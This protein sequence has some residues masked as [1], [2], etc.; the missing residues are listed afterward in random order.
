MSKTL[1]LLWLGSAGAQA[2]H[3]AVLDSWASARWVELEAPAADAPAGVRY[4]DALSQKLEELLDQARLAASSLDD[5]TAR[6]RLTDIDRTL[7]RN[8]ALPQ[9]AWLMAE[10]L[11]VEASIAARSSPDARSKLLERAAILEGRRAPPFGEPSSEPTAPTELTVSLTSARI[12]DQLYVDGQRVSRRVGLR[13]GEHHVRV[14]RRER[15]VWAGWVPVE[16]AGELGLPIPAPVPCSLDD[17]EGVSVQ[18]DRVSAAPSTACARWAVARP[19]AGGGIEIASCRGAS[20]GPLMTW[21]RHYGAVYSG[22]PQPP[23]EPGFPAWAT[24]ALVGAGAA[25]LTGAVLWQAGAFDEP[26]PGGRRFELWGPG[27][28]GT[29]LRSNARGRR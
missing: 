4:D 3:E 23:P 17:L 12:T 10:A 19:A 24:W 16:R 22:P 29:G 13:A 25:A 2:T 9:A 14:V 28:R 18:R 11:Q 5:A 8:A 26:E 6:E 15:V 20:C 1:V 7:R 27:Q 21:K